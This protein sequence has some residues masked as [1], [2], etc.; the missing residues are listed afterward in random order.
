MKDETKLVTLGRHP[1]RNYGIINPPVYHASTVLFPTIEAL[2]NAPAGSSRQVTYG[3]HGTPTQHGLADALAELE[4]GHDT[5]LFSSGLAAITVAMLAYLK[6]GDQVLMT[7]S[8]YGPTRRFCEVW[9]KRF[10]IET[11]YYH[12][13]IGEGI[14]SLMRPET[15]V[16]FTESPGSLT[17]EIQDIPAICRVAR[18]HNAIV[19][20]DNTWASPLYFKPFDFGVDVSIQAATKYI[21]G[22]SDVM[23]GSVT[24]NAEAW[25][26]LAK[27]ALHFGQ[28]GAPDDCYLV[29]RGLRTLAVRLGRHQDSG[30]KLARWLQKRPEVDRVLH[31]A[32]PE[33][34]GHALWKRD[35][36]GAS[37]LFAVQLKPCSKKGLAA[38]LEGMTLFGMGYSWG[39]Y[40]SLIIPIDLT[41]IRTVT[42]WT[43]Q[44]PLLRIHAGLEDADDL[45]AD[46]K[47]GF[48]RLH[49]ADE[50]R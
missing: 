34:P 36:S 19:M 2:E 20:L 31:P 24:A 21:C 10:G 46:L 32:L 8:V 17:F 50:H 40:E 47:Q 38:M 5:W 45:I 1:E 28:Q 27:A 48:E 11:T 7:D 13:L 37:G 4:G 16:V 41:R 12:P 44:G 35:F 49:N 14:E 29:Q 23:L 18:N 42:T 26:A 6:T 9:L 15:R 43:G 25:P 39:G 30:L 22:H 33:H 3:L